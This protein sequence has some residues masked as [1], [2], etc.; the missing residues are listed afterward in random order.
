[1][2][3][4]KGLLIGTLYT[5][6][7]FGLAFLFLHMGAIIMLNQSGVEFLKTIEAGRVSVYNTY[8]SV[9]PTGWVVKVLNDKAYYSIC[10]VVFLLIWISNVNR[11][12]NN[13]KE[14]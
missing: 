4:V 11:Q 14:E 9:N 3:L 12:I 10:A 8:L 13:Y 2:A 6:L 7:G 1:M 5:L